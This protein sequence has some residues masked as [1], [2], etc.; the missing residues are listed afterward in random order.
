MCYHYRKT[1]LMGMGKRTISPARHTV[2]GL[3]C[4]AMAQLDEACKLFISG[5]PFPFPYDDTAVQYIH[6]PECRSG[7]ASGERRMP[8][9]DVGCLFLTCIILWFSYQSG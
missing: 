8:R 3:G 6:I 7:R 5:M 1:N 4:N 2:A 9:I